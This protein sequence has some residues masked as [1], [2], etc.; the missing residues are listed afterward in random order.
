MENKVKMTETI[1]VPKEG[2]FYRIGFFVLFSLFMLLVGG[3][4]TWY[5]LGVRSARNIE[6]LKDAQSPT[7]TINQVVSVIPSP[8]TPVIPTE[9]EKATIAPTIPQKSDLEQIR[10]AMAAKY[11]KPVNQTTVTISK[12]T[13]THASGGVKFEG[14]MG[15]GWLLAAKSGGK[16]VIVADGNGTIS[17]EVIAPYNFP[18]SIVSE[19]VDNNGK[20]IK[21]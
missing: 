5:F 21:R 1:G 10:E 8:T 14:E 11:N 19:C 3:T 13:G 16:W 6:S 20:V 18:S 17:C 7:V 2:N 12:N 9:E 15:G 4:L